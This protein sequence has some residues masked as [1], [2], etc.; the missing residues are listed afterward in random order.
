MTVSRDPSEDS[1]TTIK[2]DILA[3][4]DRQ[5]MEAVNLLC[6]LSKINNKEK[7]IDAIQ[8]IQ[9]AATCYPTFF[10]PLTQDPAQVKINFHA[11]FSQLMSHTDNAHYPSLLILPLINNYN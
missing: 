10:I 9:L 7:R 11:F 2:N 5:V 4:T 1:L 3:L 8:L 6:E